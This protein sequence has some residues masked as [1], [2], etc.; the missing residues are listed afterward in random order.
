[1]GRK[2]KGEYISCLL[3]RTAGTQTEFSIY[4]QVNYNTLFLTLRHAF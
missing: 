3:T 2:I 4:G 1:M